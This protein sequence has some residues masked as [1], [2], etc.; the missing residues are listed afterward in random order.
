MHTEVEVH[1]MHLFKG[2]DV[3]PFSQSNLSDEVEAMPAHGT[4][5]QTVLWQ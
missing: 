3:L 1:I 5:R 2:M 4:W